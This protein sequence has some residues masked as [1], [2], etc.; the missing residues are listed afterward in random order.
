VLVADGDNANVLW[1]KFKTS[2][3]ESLA[4]YFTNRRNM[5]SQDRLF[6]R[7]LST[8]GSGT[9]QF[10]ALIHSWRAG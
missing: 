4:F 6:R 8:K 7:C 2:T 1:P 9:N 3:V 10:V 5:V